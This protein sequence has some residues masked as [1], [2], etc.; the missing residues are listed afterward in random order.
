MRE[1]GIQAQYVKPYTVTT[2]EPDLSSRLRKQGE[3]H[4]SKNLNMK[5]ATFLFSQTKSKKRRFCV[6]FSFYEIENFSEH[7]SYLDE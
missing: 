3:T 7:E 2:I 4:F 6:V 5:K 1:L